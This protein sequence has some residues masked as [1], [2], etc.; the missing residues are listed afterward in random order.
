M[1]SL[2]DGPWRRFALLALILLSPV[3]GGAVACCFVFLGLCSGAIGSGVT[4]SLGFL[5]SY[6]EGLL[7]A[8]ELGLLI[9]YSYL[10]VPIGGILILVT[11]Y[12]LG[13]ALL[14]TASAAR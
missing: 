3:G 12:S 7:V 5:S 6:Y 1:Y 10:W 9:P 14:A 8:V 13:H 2:I 11:I 4:C